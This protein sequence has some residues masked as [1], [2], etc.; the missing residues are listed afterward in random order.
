MLGV[1]ATLAL[2]AATVQRYSGV[3]CTLHSTVL[4]K[5]CSSQCAL[6]KV[7]IS[8]SDLGTTRRTYQQVWRCCSTTAKASTG[9][10]ALL[11]PEVDGS[12]V[13]GWTGHT[14]GSRD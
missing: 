12:Q 5:D 1:K 10:S 4:L 9:G 2:C 14:K 13:E 7:H 11:G 3:E 6:A 8:V